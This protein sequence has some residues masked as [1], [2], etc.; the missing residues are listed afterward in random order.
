MIGFF[1][2]GT[3]GDYFKKIDP[4]LLEP[5]IRGTL[6]AAANFRLSE[7]KIFSEEDITEVVRMVW[8]GTK[9]Q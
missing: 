3:D 7:H 4:G 2:A 6:V 8:D 1:Q 5:T 9:R